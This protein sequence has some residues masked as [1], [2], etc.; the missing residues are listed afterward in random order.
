MDREGWQRMSP[1]EWRI[2]PTGDMRVPAILYALRHQACEPRTATTDMG[3]LPSAVHFSCFGRRDGEQ[4][5]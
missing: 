2:A 5:C 3:M 1:I 4:P